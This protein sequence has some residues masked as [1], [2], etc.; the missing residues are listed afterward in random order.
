MHLVALAAVAAAS[1]SPA[2][3]AGLSAALDQ[4]VF[5]NEG[6]VRRAPFALRPYASN[7][8]SSPCPPPKGVSKAGDEYVWKE[9]VPLDGTGDILMEP[10]NITSSKWSWPRPGSFPYRYL[11]SNSS[12]PRTCSPLSQTKG[13]DQKGDDIR[14]FQLDKADPDLCAAACC[15]DFEANGTCVAYVYAPTPADY[16]TCKK[17]Q[18]CCFLK[19]KVQT[20][21]PSKDVG[22]ISGAVATSGGDTLKTPPSGMRSAVPL[23]GITTGAVELRGDGSFHEWTII[24]QTPGGSAKIQ[25]YPEAFLAA[26]VGEGSARVLQTSPLVNAPGV[27]Q[28]RYSGTYP[29]SRLQFDDDQLQDT[30]LFAFSAYRVGDQPASSRPG[31]AFTLSIPEGT[32][33]DFMFQLPINLETDQIRAGTPLPSSLQPGADAASTSIDC[34]EA[35][36]N[37][38]KCASWTFDREKSTC[39]LQS[40]APANWYRLGVDSGL[41]YSWKMD[42]DAGCLNLVRPGTS[43]ASGG[44]ALC[45]ASD[46]PLGKWSAGTSSDPT[47][48]FER[49]AANG[50]VAGPSLDGAFGAIAVS[51]TGSLV[52]TMG[53]YFPAKDHYGQVVGNQYAVYYPSAQAAAWGSV[54]I[55]Q[56]AGALSQVVN[57]IW[58]MHEPFMGTKSAIPTW[59][60]DQLVNGLSHIRT[61]M[62]FANCTGCH[63]S[64]DPRLEGTGFWR[65]WESY[66]CDDLDS[67][68]ND[69][70][71]HIPYI[72][73]FPNSTRSKLAAWAGNQ[74]P[75]G[76]LAEQI[77]NKSPDT[78][79][80]RV[81]SD[82]SSMFMV[83]LLELLNWDADITS[84]QLYWPTVQKIVDWIIS[85]TSTIGVP[86]QLQTTYDQL[87]FND[88]QAS[89]YSTGFHLLAMRVGQELATAMGDNATYDKCTESLKRVTAAFDEM[90]WQSDHYAATSDQCSSGKPCGKQVGVFADTFYPQVLAYS[91]SLGPLVNESR[92]SS[93]QNVVVKENCKYPDGKGGLIPNKCPNGLLTVTGRTSG[94]GKTHT[95]NELWQMIN[96]DYAA[97][98]LNLGQGLQDSLA[99]SKGSALSWSQGVNDQWGTAALSDAAGLP[100]CIN[101]YGYHMTSWHIPYA[102][103]GQK[104]RLFPAGSASLTFN[105]QGRFSTGDWSLPVY[106]AGRLGAISREGGQYILSLNFGSLKLKT[107]SVDGCA[108]ASQS[109]LVRVAPGQPASWPTCA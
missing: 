73:F 30:S 99:F 40:D 93:H 87:R 109:D 50:T 79:Q 67:I 72:S 11:K 22:I 83:Y 77:L 49:F 41:R 56:R 104:A 1:A 101:H 58:A 24:N 44:M 64:K 82:S 63:R 102:M 23:G 36:Q 95:D 57:D 20:P 71:R 108:Y 86:Y 8:C 59:L 65:Q 60:Q 81:M 78:P 69:G 53:W 14:A 45:V 13:M 32:S 17:G 80:G 47:A 35:C 68:H 21:T 48:L 75:D 103:S 27:S 62:W 54:P 34:L 61:A 9:I 38:D 84:L 33:A 39:T 107:L 26:R 90:Q 12:T 43:P 92:L 89:S 74:Q 31:V 4:L 3:P 15:A 91:N 55:D 70:E 97:I 6:T 85:T 46:Q 10:D 94:G 25:Q 76:M 66:A 29:V 42:S 98:A 28:I 19:S 5:L 106:L 16:A 52:V 18:P 7:K 100:T 51:G 2:A 37:N 105:T 88:H 96:H